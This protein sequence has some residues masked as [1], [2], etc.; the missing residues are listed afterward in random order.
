MTERTSS[1]LRAV[2]DSADDERVEEAKKVVCAHTSSLI[3]SPPVIS[4]AWSRN[5]MSCSPKI[6]YPEFRFSSWETKPI[7]RYVRAAS[8]TAIGLI[9]TRVF[10]TAL[11]AKQLIVALNLAEMLSVEDCEKWQLQQQ[12]LQQ[13]QQ[14]QQQE[15]LVKVSSEGVIEMHDWRS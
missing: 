4:V 12:Q 7:F 2:V 3:R 9:G 15:R 8:S 10:Q 1:S 5:C 13:Q 11:P 6:T 14:Q